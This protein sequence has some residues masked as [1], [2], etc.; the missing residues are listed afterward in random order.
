MRSEK[1]RWAL[2]WAHFLLFI[3]LQN[4]LIISSRGDQ[5]QNAKMEGQNA[6]MDGQNAKMD[7]QN[8]K[9]EG[10]SGHQNMIIMPPDVSP[11]PILATI[12]ALPHDAASSPVPIASKSVQ[13]DSNAVI[14][15][16]PTT[17]PSLSNGP[18]SIWSGGWLQMPGLISVPRNNNNNLIVPPFS[19]L[20]LLTKRDD[21]HQRQADI[22]PEGKERREGKNDSETDRMPNT[23]QFVGIRARFNP[24]IFEETS[25]LFFNVFNHE[26]QHVQ[27]RPQKQCF[28]EGCFHLHTF[29]ISSFQ[30]PRSL[31]LKPL[32]PNVLLLDILSFDV[33][34]ESLLNGSVQLLITSVP[35]T[36]NFYVSARQL[37]ITALFDLQKDQ[38]KVPYLRIATCELRSGMI[39]TKVT[40]MGLLTEPINMK[41]K[42][43]MLD[44]AKELITS[45][46]CETISDTIRERVNLVLRR[47]PRAISV[48][49]IISSFVSSDSDD[50]SSSPP[51]AL[52][53]DRPSSAQR[54]YSNLLT[55]SYN[56]HKR[57]NGNRRA[58][59][60]KRFWL[61]TQ[62]RRR[63]GL[64]VI[65]FETDKSPAASSTKSAEKSAGIVDKNK[66]VTAAQQKEVPTLLSGGWDKFG[67]N[68]K[69]HFG[70][71]GT[72]SARR[73]ALSAECPTDFA[74]TFLDLL[75]MHSLGQVFIDLDFLDSSAGSDFFAVG[76]SGNVFM[77]PPVPMTNV[78]T[79]LIEDIVQ[80]RPKSAKKLVEDEDKSLLRDADELETD[81][82]QREN[83][84]RT[85]APPPPMLR[86]PGVGLNGY[87][88]K[89]VE[90]IISELSVNDAL[91]QAFRAKMMKVRLGPNSAMFG[92]MLRTTC[93]PDEVCLS[94]SVPELGEKYPDQ[95]LEIEIEP[96]H[97]PNIK[98]AKDSVTVHL[99]GNA[100]ILLS[101]NGKSIGR[102]PFASVVELGM[103][104]NSSKSQSATT[105]LDETAADNTTA[106]TG[107]HGKIMDVSLSIPTLA[108]RG[109]AF[110]F[111]GLSPQ[112]VES[113][114]N[115]VRNAIQNTAGKALSSGVSLVGL[116]RHLC[117]YGISQPGIQLLDD[118]LVLLNAEL[119]AYVLL[120][121]G[122][123]IGTRQKQQQKRRHCSPTEL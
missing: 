29:R 59:R 74:T 93:G 119:D 92:Q 63:R 7:G 43:E 81:Q 33:D 32:G 118:G 116:E 65:D 89:A 62:R 11:V 9:I 39:N 83:N 49:K 115:T 80:M 31:T 109:D 50:C 87:Q 114:L 67:K 15:T 69:E 102:I 10:Q 75:D 3:I 88:R 24:P 101:Q 94:D 95:Q 16:V 68:S 99:V 22:T 54:F 120:F 100:T 12:S 82:Q 19:P 57:R 121:D 25:R 47:M 123:G 58:S 53:L 61:R 4:I 2:L 14:E 55:M 78:N 64:E 56:K 96:V 23:A 117:P 5:S 111:F 28:A 48:A 41:Y 72:S 51:I 6:K 35:I 104:R 52:Q 1:R 107:T 110:D 97:A 27:I 26:A 85:K 90:M 84:R 112:T 45:T 30:K 103:A 60:G 71:N 106:T 46:I 8:A 34:I 108:L 91:Q 76:I 98:F 44:K 37:S 42:T 73:N 66:T 38:H 21:Q 86:F 113:F 122:G 77:D 105:K 40:N 20:A 70:H 36:G 13:L 18:S 79:E 17:I